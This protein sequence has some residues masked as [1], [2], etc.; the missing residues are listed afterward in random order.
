MTSR[1]YA[2]DVGDEN[3]EGAPAG[4]SR[5]TEVH[6]G[7]TELR[8]VLTAV[9]RQNQL[10]MF[11]T[12]PVKLIGMSP[13]GKRE[14]PVAATNKL[15]A[16]IP[17]HF[18]QSLNSI[19]TLIRIVNVSERGISVLRAMPRAIKAI[20]KAK[21]TED[22]ADT[23][24]QIESAEKEAALAQQEVEKNF[25]VLHGLAV[26][27][28]W[29]WLEN[30]VKEFVVLWLLHRKDAYSV[31]A[32]QKLKVRLGEYLQLSKTEQAHYVVELLEQDLASPLKRGVTRFDS[33][34]EPFGLVA[35]PLPEGCAKTLFELQQVRNAIAHKNG[36]ADR[37]LKSACPWL[38]VKLNQPVPVSHEMLHAYTG[39]CMQYLVVRL[40]DVG[41]R[42]V[43]NLRPDDEEPPRIV[44]KT[45]H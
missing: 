25:P 9:L 26:V 32:L 31:A 45:G 33:L 8:L 28:L 10:M 23:A 42:Y 36:N 3:K 24:R 5:E 44:G 4:L 7:Y 38:K 19:Q 16:W 2:S 15:P 40:Y 21:D 34:F 11:E 13:K 12:L 35:T 17:D 14:P 43:T 6:G 22:T 37:Q 29:S 39:A 30:F 20:A 27:A 18:E 41:D 1:T